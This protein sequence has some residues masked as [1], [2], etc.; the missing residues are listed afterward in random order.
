MEKLV[1]N[2]ILCHLVENGLLSLKQFGFVSR[3]ST[4]TQLLN[5]LD[6]CADVVA[7][8]GNVDSIYFDFSKAFDTVPHK[9]LSVKMKAYR[10]EGK[11]LSFLTGREQGSVL[12]PLLFVIY[13]NDLPDVV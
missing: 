1:R 7:S 12:G 5:Y 13:I 10:I 4:V 3:R 6:T 11:L 2:K 8:G 9:R